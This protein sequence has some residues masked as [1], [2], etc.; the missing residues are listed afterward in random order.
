MIVREATE[1]ERETLFP[2]LPDANVFV[3]VDGETMLGSVAYRTAGDMFYA[4]DLYL[5]DE[6][7]RGTVMLWQAVRHRA[8]KLGYEHV[9]FDVEPKYPRL[10]KLLESGT[11]ELV[12]V[13]LRIKS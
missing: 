9:T 2:T 8:Q 4:H 1:Q 6:S 7:S 3:L 13:R 12:S 10:L 11:A 5:L